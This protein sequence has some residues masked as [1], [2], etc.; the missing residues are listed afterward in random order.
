MTRIVASLGVVVLL[1]ACTAAPERAATPAP[2]TTAARE[3]D[4]I[5]D[6]RPNVLVIV[7]PEAGADAVAAMPATRRFFADRGTTFTNAHTTT[8]R[9]IPAGASILTGRYA[10]NHRVFNGGRRPASFTRS[11]LQYYFRQETDY[12]TRLVAGSMKS[13]SRAGLSFIRSTEAQDERPW[14]LYVATGTGR[15]RAVDDFIARIARLLIRNDEER[16]TLAFFTAY[17][18]SRRPTH[19][20]LLVRWPGYFEAGA[21]VE[22]LVAHVDI[23]PTI[24]DAAGL[25]PDRRYPV[26]G[27]SLLPTR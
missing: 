7:I 15:A 14:F 5:V 9:A 20:P 1:A 17:R 3:P 4:A 23:A 10:H 12:R 2:T 25:I 6:A 27:T 13:V 24:M 26:D 21:R 18:G 16:T 8:P 22:S 11:T 19:I